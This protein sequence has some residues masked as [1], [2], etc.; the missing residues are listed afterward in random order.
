[1]SLLAPKG[2]SRPQT[3]DTPLLSPSNGAAAQ[4]GVT[5]AL[6]SNPLNAPAKRKRDSSLSVDIRDSK[7]SLHD[8]FEKC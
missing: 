2:V 1:M 3:P 6:A 5:V 7:R 8:T 4:G